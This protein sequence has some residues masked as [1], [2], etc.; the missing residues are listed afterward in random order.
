MSELGIALRNITRNRKRTL[1]ALSAIALGVAA[2]IFA[3]GFIHWIL[4]ELREETIRSQLGHIQVRLGEH[5]AVTPIAGRT[6]SDDATLVAKLSKS[7]H[8]LA[9]LPRVSF[10]GLASSGEITV[11]FVGEGIDPAKEALGGGRWDALATIPAPTAVNQV[12]L[13]EGLAA[14]LEVERG[15]K[16]VLIVNIPGGGINAAEANVIEVFHTLSKAYDDVALRAPLSLVHR[17]IRREG[18]DHWIVFLDDTDVTGDVLAAMRADPA[19]ANLVFTPWTELADFYNKAVALYARQ[20]EV[21]R[22]LTALIIILSISNTMIMSVSERTSEI[23]TIMALGGSRSAVLRLF[24]IEGATLGAIG[25]FL[26]VVAGGAI[27]AAVSFVGIAMPP[28]PGMRH[29]FEAQALFTPGIA[30]SAFVLALATTTI[31]SLY[32]AWRASRLGIVDAIR[33]A[34]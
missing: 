28:A 19:L 34:Y 32:P 30:A 5:D 13:G 22:V 33:H 14:S 26:G 10:S 16:V 8:V 2:L 1:I 6:P 25:G 11:S 7:A 9:V 21:V 17:L 3:G 20:F 24:L 15:G 12:A 18:A 23:G 31:A 27:N 29:G 4:R